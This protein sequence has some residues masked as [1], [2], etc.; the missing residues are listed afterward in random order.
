MLAAVFESMTPEQVAG[1]QGVLK[2]EQLANLVRIAEEIQA[3]RHPAK[4]GG[5]EPGAQKP[6]R[7]TDE[8][9]YLA[10]TK[11]KKDLLPWAAA[12]VKENQPLQPPPELEKVARIFTLFVGALTAAQFDEFMTKD[13]PFDAEERKVFVRLAEAFKVVPKGAASGTA[14]ADPSTS[15]GGA[16]AP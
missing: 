2:P 8:T 16:A 9:A 1:L 14:A 10:V 13:V 4:A 6:E 5:G 3:T 7:F 12:R 11:I 15:S